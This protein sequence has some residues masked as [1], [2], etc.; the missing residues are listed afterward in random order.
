MFDR[1]IVLQ[2]LANMTT[3][4]AKEQFMT[5]F[6]DFMNRNI[7]K[8][9]QLYTTLLDPATPFN[10]KMK[11]ELSVP[12]NVRLNSLAMMHTHI[13]RNETKIRNAL[14]SLPDEEQAQAM[15]SVLND[16]MAKY[17]EP[18]KKSKEKKDLEASKGH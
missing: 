8:M 16:I 10:H 12:E 4:G 18:P 17:G 1:S 3:L 9:K 2:N 13:F 5:N 11:L 14:Q 6:E 15:A 7:P